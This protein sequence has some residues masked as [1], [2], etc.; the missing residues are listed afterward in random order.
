MTRPMRQRHLQV[1]IA[2]AVA[3]PLLFIAAMAARRDATPVNS[4][5]VWEQFP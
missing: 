4:H 2:L 1:W 3:L 5:L